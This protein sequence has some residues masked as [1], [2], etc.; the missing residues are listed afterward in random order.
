MRAIELVA[1]LGWKMLPFYQV[2]GIT[3]VWR[4]NGQPIELASSLDDL[5][6]AESCAGITG[7]ES[8]KI[9]LTRLC[10]AAEEMLEAA[11]QSDAIPALMLGE[12]SERLR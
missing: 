9:T 3:G 5:S 7:N 11:H 4:F 8:E 12:E 10:A 2:Y 1:S 6:F